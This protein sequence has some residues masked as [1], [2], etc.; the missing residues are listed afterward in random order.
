MGASEARGKLRQGEQS[1]LLGLWTGKRE[2]AGSKSLLGRDLRADAR[3]V[4]N[5]MGS[6]MVPTEQLDRRKVMPLNK[7]TGESAEM[8]D[9]QTNKSVHEQ[10]YS[11]PE[12]RGS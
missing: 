1:L 4:G 5:R 7:S 10:S 12:N 2:E 8:G 11:D 3:A 6:E 9:A